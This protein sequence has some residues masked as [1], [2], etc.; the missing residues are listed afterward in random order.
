MRN[1]MNCDEETGNFEFSPKSCQSHRFLSSVAQTYRAIGS[2]LGARMHNFAD[3]L[4]KAVSR[5]S[6]QDVNLTDH[7]LLMLTHRNSFLLTRGRRRDGDDSCIF[8]S[9]QPAVVA[10]PLTESHNMNISKE[11][12]SS[13]IGY[14]RVSTEKQA[15]GDKDF[16]KQAQ[17]IRKACARRGI[18][19]LG[20]YED[21]ASG[22]DPLG[23]IRRGDLKAA[24]EKAQFER[25]VLV[26]P[27]ATRLFR[28]V[29]AARSFLDALDV[30]IFSVREG[31]FLGKRALLSAIA[32]GEEVARNISIGTSNALAHKK[33]KG[34]VFNDQ[35]GRV[36]A[37]KASA[38]ARSQ[39]SR[40]L[41][42]DIVRVL[43]TVP[44][45]RSLNHEKF[46]DLLNAEGI[47]TGKNRLWTRDGVRRP[48]KAA[49]EIIAEWEEIAKEDADD[50]PL[51]NMTHGFSRTDQPAQPTAPFNPDDPE[52]ELLRNPIYGMF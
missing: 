10:H 45:A 21:T 23:H 19:L 35:A 52:G 14:I 6:S 11:Y 33:A 46:A 1:S 29:E 32:R 12:P 37:A 18:K 4:V 15:K 41:V 13:A 22:V 34:V 49:E 3:A 7:T 40:A 44:S 31:R 28:N 43:R 39:K 36:S 9:D 27:E 51:E 26:I 38:K 48:R 30:P 24:A 50:S 16:E 20:I 42:L 2:V 8:S 17:G 5:Y 25:A 47:L